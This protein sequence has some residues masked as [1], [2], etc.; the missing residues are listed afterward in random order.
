M[1]TGIQARGAADVAE[2]WVTELRALK[3]DGCTTPENYASYLRDF[4][5][6]LAAEGLRYDL[7]DRPACIRFISDRRKLNQ[8]SSVRVKV[9]VLKTW[10]GWLKDRGYVL[11]NPWE[12]LKVQTPLKKPELL[13]QEEIKR[14]IEA[15]AGRPR[16]FALIHMLY[17]TGGRRA[18]LSGLDVG[19]VDL[20]GGDIVLR[21]TKG[22]IER[23]GLVHSKA[24]AATRAW[25]A[26]RK[27]IL[28]RKG[29]VGESALFVTR[30]GIRLSPDMIWATVRAVGKR[31]GLD[32]K[33]K[34]HT[35]R[36]TYATDLLENGADLRVVQELL[37]HS[38]ITST[39]RYTHVR[40]AH[41]R[42]AYLKAHPLA[43]E[44][45]D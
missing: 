23:S 9:A 11:D 43:D 19:D 15:C 2:E 5:R 39:Q 28:E 8:A 31:A 24:A 3:G 14:V 30:S 42:A 35:F 34:P 40:P 29:K 27:A 13:S 18:E 6:W 12:R 21:K 4:L 38:R 17:A 1:A 37:G 26:R 25:L 41:M 33:L 44:K 32:K 36:H 45:P 7:M 10:Y 20:S 22:D 16:D